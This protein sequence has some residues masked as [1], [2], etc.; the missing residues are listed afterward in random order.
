L[1]Y[2]GHRNL[3]PCCQSQRDADDVLLRDVALKESIRCNTL[4][5]LG[6]GGVLHVAV[7][8]H[9]P[10][11]DL[12]QSGHAVA[13]ASSGSNFLASDYVRGLS[14]R[15]E[16]AVCYGFRAVGSC[17]RQLRFPFGLGPSQV[18]L[19]FGYDLRGSVFGQRLAVPMLKTLDSD[20]TLSLQGPREHYR[21]SVGGAVGGFIGS[22]QVGNAVSINHQRLPAKC[23]PAS[24]VGFNIPL[25][26]RRLA[27]T[28]AIHI[29]GR[30]E[31]IEAME[32][33]P[34]RS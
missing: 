25:E 21:G 5:F 13:K 17:G 16:V 14:R 30:A 12:R 1:K 33:R 11:I 22:K 6:V 34:L 20:E 29:D 24:L 4:E 23:F 3:V 15:T 27:L 32:N 31:I 18:F 19:E 2:G 8:Y 28:Q 7:E 26:P 10:S 9:N